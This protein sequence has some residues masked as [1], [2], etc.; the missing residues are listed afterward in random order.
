MPGLALYDIAPVE[1]RV[2]E[3][4]GL[5]AGSAAAAAADATRACVD[6]G[7]FG[8]LL[9]HLL[10]AYP[11]AFTSGTDEGAWGPPMVSRP[12]RCPWQGVP[13]HA[14]R[15]ALAALRSPPALPPPNKVPSAPPSSP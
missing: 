1:D 7:D 12:G 6:A 2:G 15:A 4:L 14:S 10:D 9:A 3:L 8:G 13:C 11:G 5:V